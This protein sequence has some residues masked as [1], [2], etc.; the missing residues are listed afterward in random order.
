MGD[1]FIFSATD[2]GAGTELFSVSLAYLAT[3]RETL[4]LPAAVSHLEPGYP[5]PASSVITFPVT[6][7]TGGQA[8]ALLFDI[9]GRRHVA[10]MEWA[11]DRLRIDTS[12]L[13]AGVYFVRTSD[14]EHSST[15]RF[16]KR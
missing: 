4:T 3:D 12:R 15:R 5:N 11:D 6:P 1:Q 13:P 14:A 2:P 8:E 10:P 7:R 9:L 16:V